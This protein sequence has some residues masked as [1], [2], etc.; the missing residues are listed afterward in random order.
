M[1]AQPHVVALRLAGP[2]ASP[3]AWR[4]LLASAL[5]LVSSAACSEDDDSLP[6]PPALGFKVAADGYPTWSPDGEYVAYRRG[7]FSSQGPPGI[8]LIRRDGSDN[9]LLLDET[10]FYGQ[11][12]VLL[13]EI[14]FSP[15]G[16]QITVTKDLEVYL[17]DVLQALS[18]S[19]RTQVRMRHNPTGHPT[20]RESFIIG[21]SIGRR[22]WTLQDSTLLMWQLVRSERYSMMASGSQVAICA[23]L[24]QGNP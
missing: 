12:F 11:G 23:G 5:F 22:S 8:Y 4:G 1:L 16:H 10:S 15:D 3:R 14:R 6:A 21:R 7:V 20:A 2:E 9:R 24:P 18:R 17:L 13:Q 19:L